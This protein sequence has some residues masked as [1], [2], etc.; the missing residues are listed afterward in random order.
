ME[1]EN[2]NLKRKET[3]MKKTTYIRE[4]A[5]SVVADYELKLKELNEANTASQKLDMIETVLQAEIVA[6]EMISLL[7]YIDKQNR[8]TEDLEKVL[9]DSVERM[10]NH[11][12]GTGTWAGNGPWTP[13]CTAWDGN[14]KN[15]V[16]ANAV[17]ELIC[18]M[19]RFLGG[20]WRWS[21]W[22]D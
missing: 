11:L 7:R 10:T 16:Q 19:K 18:I 1:S 9:K 2:K 20:G 12:I 21:C 6:G 14:V 5:A 13:N 8:T 4:E 17:R 22:N 15:I 3:K